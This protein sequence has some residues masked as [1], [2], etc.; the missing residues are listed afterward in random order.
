MLQHQPMPTKILPLC[1]PSPRLAHPF[2][3]PPPLQVLAP[4]AHALQHPHVRRYFFPYQATEK[5]LLHAC[6]MGF[7]RSV[8][9]LLRL[10]LV[11]PTSMPARRGLTAAQGHAGVPQY[12]DVAGALVAHGVQPVPT[13]SE[14]VPAHVCVAVAAYSIVVLGVCASRN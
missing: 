10:G 11:R 2:A 9:E 6:Q 5:A 7:P 13:L 14:V 8:R 4:L 3:F 12:D 1:R